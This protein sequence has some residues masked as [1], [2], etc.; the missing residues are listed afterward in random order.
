MTEA[1][2]KFKSHCADIEK[3]VAEIERAKLLPGAFVRRFDNIHLQ[4]YNGQGNG[5]AYRLAKTALRDAAILHRRTGEAE[6]DRIILEQTAKIETLRA[7]LPELAA[8]ASIA[9]GVLARAEALAVINV[10]ASL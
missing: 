10:S 6:R 9:F 7:S 1:I 5:V 8:K 2:E 3:A 4:D